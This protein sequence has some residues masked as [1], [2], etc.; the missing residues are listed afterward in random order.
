MVSARPNRHI[1]V[2]EDDP[3]IAELMSV[4]LEQAGFRVTVCANGGE[5]QKMVERELPALVISD[6]WLPG[7]DGVKLAKILKSTQDTKHIPIVLVS[8]QEKLESAMKKAKADAFLPKPFDLA[9]LVAV[10]EKFTA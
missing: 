7:L 2:A 6:L 10:A 1:L 8:A 3:G 9:E 4:V 5:V